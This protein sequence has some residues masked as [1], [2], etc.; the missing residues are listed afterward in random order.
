MKLSTARSNEK[1]DEK[2]LSPRKGREGFR[3]RR[4]KGH[5]LLIHH[6]LF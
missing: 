6:T 1:E 4:I 5:V 2:T 3:K